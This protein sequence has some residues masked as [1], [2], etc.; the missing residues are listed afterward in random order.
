MSRR[1]TGDKTHIEQNESAFGCIATVRGENGQAGAFSMFFD[2]VSD[3]L[4]VTN[5]AR[6]QRWA[7]PQRIFVAGH[8]AGGTLAMLAALASPHYR[9]A[10]R[11]PARPTNSSWPKAG[12]RSCRS[13]RT[14]RQST[15]YA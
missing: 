5:H 11:S 7:D 6:S 9:A 15:S 1:V 4:A 12:P 14:I 13:T 8:S 10:D 2:E 3:V